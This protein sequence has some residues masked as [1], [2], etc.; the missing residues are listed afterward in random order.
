LS[1]LA[2]AYSARSIQLRFQFR[3]LYDYPANL[4]LPAFKHD[5]DLFGDP[6]GY[7]VALI[8]ADEIYRQDVLAYI[9]SLTS[10]LEPLPEFRRV[11]SLT[12]VRHI[13]DNGEEVVTGKLIPSIPKSEQEL[14]K[15]KAYIQGNPLYVRRLVSEDAT[16]TMVAADMRVPAAF[17][18]IEEQRIALAAFG[19]VLDSVPRPHGVNVRL[20]GSPSVEIGETDALIGDQLVLIP[21]VVLV[22][23]LMLYLTF[24][25]TKGILLCL[26]S[27]TA[28]MLWTGGL[29]PLLGRPI[30][31][32]GSII[33]ITMLVYGVVDPI[34]VLARYRDKI[35]TG[36]SNESAIEQTMIE[37]GLPCFL[38]SLT[39]SIGF[40]SFITSVSPSVRYFGLTVAVGVLL[41]FVTTVTV[42]PLL[43]SAFGLPAS[44]S[45]KTSSP[46]VERVLHWLSHV[47]GA[48]PLT[49]VVLGCVLLSVSSAFAYKQRIENYYVGSLPIGQTQTDV[50]LFENKLA[51]VS[52]MVITFAGAENSI[53][54]PD[55]LRAIEQID[56][57]VEK[58]PLITYSSS[59]PDL[60]GE[61]H[62]AFMGGGEKPSV[63]NSSA[64]IAQYMA[65]VDP[66]DRAELVTENFSEAHIA[67]LF[68]DRGSEIILKMADDIEQIVER[69]GIRKLGVESHIGGHGIV[70]YRELDA[71]V[72]AL[73]E[74]L[75]V[76]FSIVILFIWI[77][78]RS[79]RLALLAIVPNLIPIA[80]C[81]LA[82]RWLNIP[83]RIDTVLVSCICIGGLFNT[84]IHLMARVLQS[85]KEG[86]DDADE[87][88]HGAILSIGP[89]AL[90]TTVVLTVGFAVFILS[91]FNGLQVL[92]M[93]SMITLSAGFVSDMTFTPAFIRAGFNWKSVLPPK[94]DPV[95]ETVIQTEVTGKASELSL[96][97]QE[98]A[99]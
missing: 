15:L 23:A 81:F 53:K 25:N 96:H 69:S 34:F 62:A 88:I 74:G 78:Y 83:L 73:A 40:G 50:R 48:R 16:M 71:V 12:S 92:G 29:Y 26:G 58:L 99:S 75:F 24:R 9:K 18:T 47:T 98:N 17:S 37:L 85:I 7:V 4:N 61:A 11:R 39:T 80:V 30:D 45:D 89:P 90:F 19:K 52:R 65:M 42:L 31:L 36:L 1:L 60:V 2:A 77:L 3:D 21:V 91:Q 63:P 82:T 49:M 27:V 44:S 72:L 20:T 54:R 51:G 8:E 87:I 68:R 64:L 56:R 5:I 84:T 93:L 41:A 46:A 57:E 67:I 10:T 70:A 38:T 13:H 79:W 97:T 76:A 14:A 95:P 55:V 66:Q 43:L 35:R 32:L 33:P 22:L 28:A 6:A 86:G 94:R 59:L